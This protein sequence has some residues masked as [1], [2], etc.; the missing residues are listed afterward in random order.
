MSNFEDQYPLLDPL[1]DYVGTLVAERDYLYLLRG[2]ATRRMTKGYHL[3]CFS[4]QLHIFFVNA[5]LN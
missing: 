2:L 5:T 3:N 4:V 1:T